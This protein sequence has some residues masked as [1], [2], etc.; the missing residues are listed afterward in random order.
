MVKE[1]KE[2]EA[3]DKKR[4]EEVDLKN[5]VD[6]L[7]F[8]TDKTLEE[9]K[10]KVGEDEVKKIE[11]ARDAL[12]KAQEANNIDD[13]K[14]KKDDLTKLIQDMSV[15]LYQQ[16]QQA[17]QAQGGATDGAAN[18]GNASSNDNNDDNTVD[19]DFKE[20]DPDDKN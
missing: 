5:E 19:G 9:I 8:Q 18:A 20:V 4:K 13:M 3:A 6:Q 7:L 10:G 12:K 11:D 2:N 16:A 17:Q 15:K 1:A 14:A